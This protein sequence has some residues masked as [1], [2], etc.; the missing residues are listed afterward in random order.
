MEKELAPLGELV[1]ENTQTEKTDSSETTSNEPRGTDF[2]G[3]V[4]SD[5]N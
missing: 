1:D 2:N 4:S 3:E 5:S